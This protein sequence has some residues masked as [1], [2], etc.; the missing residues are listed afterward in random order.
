MQVDRFTIRS[1]TRHQA[2]RRRFVSGVAALGISSMLATDISA[3]TADA[4]PASPS[5]TPAAS[6]VTGDTSRYLFVADRSQTAVEVY[7]VP[8]GTL[9][10]RIDDITCATHA[11]SL[12]LPD[13]RL[14]FADQK[15]ESIVTLAIG[16]DGTP[17]ITDRAPATL[18]NGAAWIAAS[19][20]LDYVAIGS[21]KGESKTQSLNVVE[22]A[23]F[24]NTAI[25]FTM[26]EDEE[27]TAWLLGDPLH[28]YVAVGGQIKSY[29]LADLLAGKDTPLNTV[30]VELGSH[31]GA[32]DAADGR[33]FFTTAPGTGFEVL[34]TSA[35]AAEY[36][37]Q[38]PWDV[39]GFS[40]GRNARPRVTGDGA[41]VFGLMTPG[42]DDP[43]QWAMTEVTNHVTDMAGL[44]ATR[45]SI[46]TG[47][48]AYRW[49]MNDAIALWAGYA[50]EDAG[51]A[52][53]IDADATS[54]TFG[55]SIATIAIP[56]P[57]NA[58]V[59]GTDFEGTD[60]Y[61]TAVTAINDLGFVSVNGDKIVLVIDLATR[62]VIGTFAIGMPMTNY[63]GYTAIIE[64]GV[65]PA[66]IWGR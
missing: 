9:A 48:F 41:H 19:P 58:A 43:T 59:P 4:T 37:T 25:E 24:T 38:I 15:N 14:L 1:I 16:E 46:G 17:A 50:E 31:G 20:A 62:A 47:N 63:D 52:Y 55:T 32:S 18:G 51:T 53:V 33:I 64:T 54:A 60:T 23:T 7:S 61:T 29:V 40:G 6:P 26:N 12:L 27:L 30:E 34:D 44:T 2:T 22:I 8:D 21:L 10:G 49:G 13:G 36:V 45:V 56:K 66:D 3:R 11:G 28:L 5:A 57:T 65:T 39:N 35:G 42:L